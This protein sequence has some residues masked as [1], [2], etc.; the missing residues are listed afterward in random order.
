[1]LRAEYEDLLKQIEH[2]KDILANIELR[3]EIIKNE[4]IEIKAKYGD[5]RKS[6]IVYASEEFNPEDFYSDDAMIITISHMGYIKRTALTEFRAQGRGGIGS[7]G[8]DSRDEDFIENIYPASMHNTMLF[9]T[10]KGKCYW[11][12]VYEIPEGTKSS[13]GRAIQNLLNIDADDKVNAFIR[14]KGLDDEEYINSHYVIFCTK[15]G[16][17]K[18]TSLKEYSRPRQNGVNAIS[19]RED[20]DVIEVRLTDGKNE[21]ILAN[22][23]G[24]AIRFN[25]M[26]VRAMGRTATGVKG[27]TL[28]EDGADEVIGMICVNPEG[29]ENILV[30]S[31]QGYG[32]RSL[33]EDYRVTNRGGKG[34]KT[35]NITEKTGKLVS[36]KSVTDENDLMIINKSGIAIRTK[37]S[38]LRVMGRATQGVRIIN[39]EKRNDEIASVCKVHSE[40]E[41]E[42]TSDKEVNSESIDIES[43]INETETNETNETNQ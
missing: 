5:E 27:M 4:L 20:D 1:K 43:G 16:I 25:E 10:Q 17:I 36:I 22:K 9:F 15:N 41:E 39:L 19:I 6:E 18:K 2:L 30:V 24:R 26:K 40:D 31:Q 23:N 34:V 32:K 14:V 8:S 38:D 7:K 33:L 35:I 29:S 12:K 42:V 13:K 3:M 28:D 11:L 21:I 37:V